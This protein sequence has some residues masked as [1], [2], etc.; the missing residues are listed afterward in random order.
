MKTNIH[1]RRG[2]RSRLGMS[3]WLMTRAM[4]RGRHQRSFHLSVWIKVYV[5]SQSVWHLQVKK[6]VFRNWKF[7]FGEVYE[8][9]HIQRPRNLFKTINSLLLPRAISPFF[10]SSLLTNGKWK[11]VWC[12]LRAPEDSGKEFS[13]WP[14]DEWWNVADWRTGKTITS[15]HGG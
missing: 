14:R 13:H 6:D 3:H 11:T 4:L 9:L 12:S 2:I 5:N 10:R 1:W 15:E 7:L 8:P